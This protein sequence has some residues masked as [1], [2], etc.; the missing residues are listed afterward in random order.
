MKTRISTKKISERRRPGGG[1]GPRGERSGADTGW[2]EIFDSI[3]GVLPPE[4]VPSVSRLADER[5]TPFQ[6]LIS[7]MISLRTKDDVTLAASRRLFERA[8]DPRKVADL[9]ESEVAALIYPAG[10]YRTKASH[11]RLVAGMIIDLHGGE[12]PASREE[13]TAMPGVGP[14]TAN[15]VLGLG[16]GIPAICVDTH[17]HRICNRLGWVHTAT[18]EETEAALAELLPREAWIELNGL[19]VAFG[20]RVCT[21]QSPWCS[22][23]PLS[24]ETEKASPEGPRIGVTRACERMNVLVSR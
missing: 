9:S 20:Q 11:I 3:R 7:T 21:P 16:F 15:L 5:V 23:C 13:L 17:V 19:F 2:R 12:V 8:P 18:P 22:R 1:R 4:S 14:K 10:F 24:P 6:I